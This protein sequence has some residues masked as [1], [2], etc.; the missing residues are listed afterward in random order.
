MIT[1]LATWTFGVTLALVAGGMSVILLGFVFPRSG[2]PAR[3]SERGQNPV[4]GWPV[5]Y[6]PVDEPDPDVSGGGKMVLRTWKYLPQHGLSGS[7]G[8]PP[9]RRP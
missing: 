1:L 6:P 3:P 8:V 9:A 2:R 7:S 5:L 4:P